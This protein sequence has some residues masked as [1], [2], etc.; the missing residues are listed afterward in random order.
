MSAVGLSAPE[1]MK[2]TAPSTTSAAPKSIVI[3]AM[4][5]P[6]GLRSHPTTRCVLVA[7][8]RQG[9]HQRPSRPSSSSASCGACRSASLADAF[10]PDATVSKSKLSPDL[11][12]DQSGWAGGS[13]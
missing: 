9:S 1:P 2:P 11:R 7:R 3:L 8:S 5:N 10:G 6:T 4:L 12:C 13:V